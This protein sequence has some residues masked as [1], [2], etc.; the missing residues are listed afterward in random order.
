MAYA[1]LLLRSVSGCSVVEPELLAS[2]SLHLDFRSSGMLPCAQRARH[3][4]WNL[5]R[6]G[7]F[8]FSFF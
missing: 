4:V 5:M 3:S 6:I 1:T 2:V 8:C 7:P